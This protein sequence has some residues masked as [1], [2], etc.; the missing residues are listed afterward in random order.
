MKSKII[1]GKTH[2]FNDNGKRL[3]SFSHI[4][5]AFSHKYLECPKKVLEEATKFGSQLSEEIQ[6]WFIEGEKG[7]LWPAIKN[8]LDI[9]KE[10]KMSAECAERHV[11]DDI[12]HG[13][14]DIDCDKCF[15][16]IKTRSKFKLDWLTIAQCEFY[17]EITKKPYII[18]Y[19][20]KNT[21]E[22]KRLIPTI[23]Q[24]LKAHLFVKTL[25]TATL[26]INENNK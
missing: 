26:L 16:E 20:N 6:N 23:D 8:I 1:D 25:K 18:I 15:V 9:I 5:S 17:Q 13:F 3:L 10:N 22:A 2:W 12:W 11:S 14:L 7:P 24:K 19:L 4:I 21:N